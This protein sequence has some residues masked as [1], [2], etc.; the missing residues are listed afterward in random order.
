MWVGDS[1][2]SKKAQNIGRLINIS[3]IIFCVWTFVF[4]HPADVLLPIV[5]AIPILVIG[6][7]W[8]YPLLYSIVNEDKYSSK[9]ELIKI[10]F[11]PGVILCLRAL[12]D[13]V[14]FEP[15]QL[16][17]PSIF[18]VLVFVLLIV[19]VSPS[20]RRSVITLGSVTLMITPYPIGTIAVL[21]SLYDHSVPHYYYPTV[22][23]GESSH[24]GKVVENTLYIEPVKLE[25]GHLITK[26]SVSRNVYAETSVG[27]EVCVVSRSGALGMSWYEVA[28]IAGCKNSQKIL[29]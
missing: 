9:V 22:I 12:M 21:N 14:L 4:P 10:L 18:S 27:D 16:I 24:G 6:L 26:L 23:Y 5:V 13:I 3:A 11:L 19:I 15:S 2:R 28:S 17:L 8:R 7:C 1:A 25:E 20:S 29:L